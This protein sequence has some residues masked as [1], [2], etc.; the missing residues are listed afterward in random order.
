MRVVTYLL[1]VFVDH[2]C[3]LDLIGDLLIGV[4]PR[5]HIMDTLLPRTRYA[6]MPKLW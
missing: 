1:D 2:P 5:T 3:Q 6:F 4:Q